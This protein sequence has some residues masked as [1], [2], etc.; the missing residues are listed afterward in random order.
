MCIITTVRSAAIAISAPLAP[1]Y[2]RALARAVAVL[3]FAYLTTTLAH[4]V[5]AIALL[6]AV[7]HSCDL[8]R[9]TA[10]LAISATTV[11]LVA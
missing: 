9:T 10:T 6:L 2:C 8:A 4:A 5:A 1:S 11:L 7:C 3:M